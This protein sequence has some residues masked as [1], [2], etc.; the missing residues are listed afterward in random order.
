VS[1][2]V[3]TWLSLTLILAAFTE[4]TLWSGI[5]SIPKGQWE[6]ACSTGLS[7]S[8]TLLHIVFPQA[9][10]MTIPSLTNRIIVITK[11][12]ALAA[13]V[14]VPDILGAAQTAVSFSSNPTPLTLG[15]IAYLVLFIPMIGLGRWVGRRYTLKR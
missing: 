15:A 2:F 4:E 11:G 6:A 7:F 1:G 8:R 9:V 5:T 13:V 14:G 3:A 10:R 12:T